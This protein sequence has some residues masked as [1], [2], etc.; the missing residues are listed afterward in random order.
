[1]KYMKILFMFFFFFSS[2]IREKREKCIY[3][4]EFNH[5]LKA[6]EP[7]VFAAVGGNRISVYECHSDDN[8]KIKLVQCYEVPDVCQNV[9]LCLISGRFQ[10]KICCFLLRIG[11]W[12]FVH[13]LLVIWCRYEKIDFGGRW[14][15][16]HYSHSLSRTIYG[17]TAKTFCRSWSGD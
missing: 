3:A 14:F 1:M 12:S 11:E 2:F 17:K 15:S 13:M 16:L 9:L 6:G 4:V 5:F 8:S 10:L 7:N